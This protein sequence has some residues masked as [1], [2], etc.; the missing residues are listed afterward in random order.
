MR[1]SAKPVKTQLNA[2][3]A[4]SKPGGHKASRS[5]QNQEA[6]QKMAKKEEQPK[7]FK[8]RQP[9]LER[10]L[11]MSKDGK[12]LIIRTIR[13]DILHVNYIQKILNKGE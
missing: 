11:S 10:K 3:P 4:P 12:W 9:I 5:F 2:A 6:R 8:E 7:A 1:K 13:T